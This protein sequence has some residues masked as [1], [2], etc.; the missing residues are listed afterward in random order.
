MN[1]DTRHD[2]VSVVMATY[3]KDQVDYLDIAIKSILNQTY[4]E[5]ELIVI[6]DGPL[7]DKASKLLS[8][9]EANGDLIWIKSEKNMGPSYARNIGIG[10]ATGKYI[11]IMDSDDISDPK[12]L[13]HQALF[14]EERG[15]DVMSCNALVID[16]QGMVVGKRR[17]PSTLYMV[18]R[19]A[20]FYSP[21][22]NPAVFGK[23]GVFKNMPY[24]ESM[25][26]SED[27]ELWIRLLKS[28]Y[29]LVNSPEYLLMYRQETSDISRRIGIN[30]AR[31]D[32]K[33]RL[34]ALTIAP[35][36][37]WP[38]VLLNAILISVLRLLPKYIFRLLY[39]FR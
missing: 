13:E 3:V 14:L 24:S 34:K 28:G 33:V 15:A 4:K 36:Y 26:V 25:R 31:S 6:S 21:M 5:I 37:L 19:L 10:R 16:G 30:Y 12:R 27:Y 11:A 32:L 17:V 35:V 8:S 38:L 39:S 29:R 1:N 20:P 18:R 23:S 9:F 2:L 7:R 22:C